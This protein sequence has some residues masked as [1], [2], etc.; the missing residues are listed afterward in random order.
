MVSPN[1]F[2]GLSV[3][4]PKMHNVLVVY[5]LKRY[6]RF[7][8]AGRTFDF[9]KKAILPARPPDRPMTQWLVHPSHRQH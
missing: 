2:N 8:P 6:G 5:S 1:A 9:R 4:A 7:Q 3:G